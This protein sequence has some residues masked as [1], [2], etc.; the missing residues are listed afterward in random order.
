[1]APWP[2]PGCGQ[3]DL[4]QLEKTLVT[5]ETRDSKAAHD[6]EAWEPEWIDSRFMCAVASKCGEVVIV[7]GRHGLEQGATYDEEGDVQVDYFDYF[8]PTWLDPAPK[9]ISL[10]RALPND[11]REDVVK[12]FQLFWVDVDACANRLRSSVDRLLDAQGVK[13]W[14]VS[15]K[16]KRV[17][18]KLH[19]RI[20]LLAKRE[21]AVAEPLM[22]VKWL[23][24]AGSHPE[25]ITRE[26][27][28]DAYEMMEYVLV[29]LVEQR[30]KL[31]TKLARTINK[32]KKPRSA[33]KRRPTSR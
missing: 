33:A 22:A 11:V 13:R 20:E 25:S 28:L 31:I 21:Q 10:P 32:A 1:M 7:S 15:K 14:T 18:L 30:S 5:Y 6:H 24:N 2:C 4:T 12:S 19:A 16:K 23:G 27:L 17:Q 9:I 26:D 3:R 29:E 8:E